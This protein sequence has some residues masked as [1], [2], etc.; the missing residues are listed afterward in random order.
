MRTLIAAAVVCL[1]LL[2]PAAMA[3]ALSFEE[4]ERTMLAANPQA[5]AARQN[6]ETAKL[7]VSAARAGLYP[8]LSANASYSRSGSQGLPSWDSYSYGLSGTQPLFA[9]AVPAALRAAGAS[10]RISQ[11]A[12]SRTASAL[13]YQLKSAF[14]D[15]I[16]SSETIKL[17][18]ETLKRRA[19]NLEL[20]RLKYQAGRE[21]KA[22][23]LETE[24]T[25]KTA[26]WQHEKYKK[27][28][29]LL[30]RKLNRLLG[31][32]ARTPAPELEPVLPPEPPEEFSFF[33]QQLE[34]H[35]SLLSARAALSA[36]E[37][38]VDSAKSAMLP[39]ASASGNYRW[40]GTD[41]P[42]APNSWALGAS[43][44]LPLFSAGRLSSN[45][46][47]SKTAWSSAEAELKNASDEVYLNAE[48]SFLTW[49]EARAYMDVA[50]SS[51]DAAEARAWLVRKQ[52]LAGQTSYFEWRNVEEQLIN[53]ENQYLAAG[54]SLIISHAAFAQ[55]IGE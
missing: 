28:L 30:E 54:R 44:S 43:V 26:Q 24:A 15:I 9:P 4:A 53:E 51:L 1:L 19:E 47:A 16:N 23:L 48:D 27:D 7:R 42:A 52:Y 8:S 40:S 50:K 36:A 22:A 14:A 37:A 13:R 5:A 34:R 12:Y 35:Y 31:R 6:L 55:A 3:A 25:L 41:W 10:M 18:Q 20:I 32:P 17:S 49:R 45:L 39:E 21:N 33:S 38:A 46:A 29:R 2:K 11:A